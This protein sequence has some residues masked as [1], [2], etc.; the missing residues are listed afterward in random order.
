M[1]AGVAVDPWIG[2]AAG[3]LFFRRSCN[4]SRPGRFRVCTSPTRP[5]VIVIVGGGAGYPAVPGR[6]VAEGDFN[7]YPIR[8]PQAICILNPLGPIPQQF[9]CCLHHGLLRGRVFALTDYTNCVYSEMAKCT[10]TP[11]FAGGSRF[12]NFGSV[13]YDLTSLTG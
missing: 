7:R 3:R 6:E 11:G 4:A 5:L 10:D 12:P 13:F 1:V 2:S 8:Y 9:L